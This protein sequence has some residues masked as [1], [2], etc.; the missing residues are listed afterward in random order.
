MQKSVIKNMKNINKNYTTKKP[1]T[2]NNMHNYV[3]N[4]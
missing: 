3:F 1:K 2:L 4:A